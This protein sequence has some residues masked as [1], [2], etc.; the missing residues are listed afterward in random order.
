MQTDEHGAVTVGCIEPRLEAALCD[1]IS[2]DRKLAMNLHCSGLQVTHDGLGAISVVNI[3]VEYDHPSYGMLC[4]RISCDGIGSP[5]CHVIYETESL[6]FAT[7]TKGRRGGG[8]D[9]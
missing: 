9:G 4:V 3:E 1:F 5:N 8:T 6:R 7:E 2:S